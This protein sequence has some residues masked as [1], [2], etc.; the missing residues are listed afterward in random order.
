MCLGSS[1]M[2]HLMTRP[3]RQGDSS[4]LRGEMRFQQN[5]FL[6]ITLSA[7]PTSLCS[8]SAWQYGAPRFQELKAEVTEVPA[9]DGSEDNAGVIL[10]FQLHIYTN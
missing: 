8:D 7:H 1:P 4:S 6:S 3:N 2:S 9:P 5:L 10:I